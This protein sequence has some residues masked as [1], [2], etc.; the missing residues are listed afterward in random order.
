MN[1]LLVH[2]FYKFPGG[3]DTV[4]NNEYNMLK[5]HGH[6]VIL[7]T[8]DNKDIKSDSLLDKGKLAFDAI[9]SKQS[10]REVKDIIEEEHIDIMHV[11]NTMTL[12][13]PSV[14]YAAKDKKIPIVQ[15]M[16]NFRHICPG[17][18]LYQKGTPCERCLNHGLCHAVIGRCYR[19]SLA[20]TLVSTLSLYINR[21]G[22]IY[23]HIN[24]IC[25]TNFNKKKLL[26]AEQYID[27]DKL[28]VRPNFI[29][30]IEYKEMP[31]D[32]AYYIYVGRIEDIKGVDIIV[33]GWEKLGNDEPDLYICGTGDK[34]SYIK[35]YIKSHNITNIKLKGFVPKEELYGLIKNARAL[36]FSSRV[37]ETFGMV[38]AESYSLRT[39]VIAA[40]FG[41][42]GRL[43]KAGYTGFKFLPENPDSL[44]SVV[45][46]MNNLTESER[47]QLGENSYKVYKKHFTKEAGYKSLMEIYKNA[48]L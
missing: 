20:E 11:H 23:K 30:E 6:N 44:C 4:V 13:S 29:P 16:H 9:F 36:V 3:E 17:A 46:H 37:Y 12:V 43:V 5:E 19:H 27:K 21:V 14:Y 18:T 1:I 7:Y 24:Y 34:E 39:P 15:T 28:F 2:N 10:Y 26:K 8:K 32:K 22:G 25:L 47:N 31:A 38:I 35:K 33:K 45:K 42:G 48:R 41:N 40:D